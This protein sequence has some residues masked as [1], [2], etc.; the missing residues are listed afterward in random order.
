MCARRL[1]SAA[2]LKPRTQEKRWNEIRA[3]GMWHYLLALKSVSKQPLHISI[4]RPTGRTT[5]QDSSSP[6]STPAIGMQYSTS[7]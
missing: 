3:T 7:H 1:V 2:F 4:S 5:T 6:D